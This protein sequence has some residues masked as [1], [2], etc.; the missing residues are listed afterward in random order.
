MYMIHVHPCA[1]CCVCI[2]TCV[3]T[4]TNAHTTSHVQRNTHTFTHPHTCFLR[5]IRTEWRSGD[6]IFIMHQHTCSIHEFFHSSRVSL[7]TPTP[8]THAGTITYVFR[9]INRACSSC[10]FFSHF[11]WSKNVSTKKDG[12]LGSRTCKFIHLYMYAYMYT[13]MYKYVYTYIFVYL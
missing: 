12:C 6:C 13:N 2:F 1:G 5:Q 4:L 10:R 7:A 8:R 9:H 11:F 3:Y